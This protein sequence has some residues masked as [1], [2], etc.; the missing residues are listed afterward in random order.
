MLRDVRAR[1]RVLRNRLRRFER[2][3]IRELH[4]WIEET[5]NLLHLSVLLF[6]PC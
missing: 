6:V 5:G 4:A 2:R 1:Y 3:E